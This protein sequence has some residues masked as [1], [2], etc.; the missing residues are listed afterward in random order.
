[1]VLPD[2]VTKMSAIQEKMP[3]ACVVLFRF[4]CNLFSSWPPKRRQNSLLPPLI[5]VMGLQSL[6]NGASN[7]MNVDSVALAEQVKGV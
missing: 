6:T 4:G 3:L 5:S 7:S 1:M 2:D